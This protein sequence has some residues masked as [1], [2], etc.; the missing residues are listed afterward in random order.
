M[1]Q[2]DF[3]SQ[4]CL[5]SAF[6]LHHSSSPIGHFPLYFFHI[7]TI[8]FFRLSI[9]YNPSPSCLLSVN[10]CVILVEGMPLPTLQCFGL[11]SNQPNYSRLYFTSF[12][13]PP[14]RPNYLNS[15]AEHP[16]NHPK[17]RP[18]S[19]AASPATP[20]DDAKYY[21]FTIDDQL[22]YLSFFQDW[23]PLNLAMVYKACILI[24]E[25]L[26]VSRFDLI[27]PSRLI[28]L[29]IRMRSFLRIDL[30]SIH[31]AIPRGKQMQ[32]C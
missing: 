17:I 1:W 31:P 25:L 5:T 30:Y 16:D 24:H 32:P 4:T 20:D 21:Y 7:S 18:I 23:G 26:E 15:Q 10:L 12:P 8:S 2:R 28:G 19:I 22:V 3:Y 14:P 6:H 29:G 27:Q 9:S 13:H 11:C